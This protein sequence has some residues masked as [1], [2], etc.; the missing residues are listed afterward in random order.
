VPT[1]RVI[2]RSSVL[3]GRQIILRDPVVK[4]G[5]DPK[6]QILFDENADRTVS[7]NHAEV[8][9][10]TI[11]PVLHPAPGKLVFRG[12]HQVTAATPLKSGDIIELAGV[13]GPAVEFIFDPP[14]QPTLA[15]TD[16]DSLA[17]TM[18]DMSVPVLGPPPSAP[19]A[20]IV[21][22]KRAQIQGGT[23]KPGGGA[24]IPRAAVPAG[25]PPGPPEQRGTE[26]LAP[27]DAEA[28][29][30]MDASQAPPS[31]AARSRTLL[32]RAVSIAAVVLVVVAVGAGLWLR[33]QRQERVRLAVQRVEALLAAQAT[34][35]IAPEVSEEDIRLFEEEV[36]ANRHAPAPGPL[37]V[38]HRGKVK[39]THVS[40]EPAE[41]KGESSEETKK[42]SAVRA[43]FADYMRAQI[44]RLS[45]G[46]PKDKS[47][48]AKALVADVKTALAA[49]ETAAKTLSTPPG[50]DVDRL[51]R[52]TIRQL[53][54]C[55]ALAPSEFLSQAKKTIEKMRTD[56]GWRERLTSG[57][58]RAADYRYGPTIT[59]ALADQGLP[60]EL[61]FIPYEMSGFDE[62]RV[63]LPTSG[64][65][66][67]GMW[68]L[69]PGPAEEMGL[70]L[71]KLVSSLDPDSGDDR[72]HYE[73]EV[74]KVAKA[75]R[76]I[77]LQKAAGSTLLF[78]ATYDRGDSVLLLSTKKRAGLA[79]Q[80]SDPANVNFWR[81]YDKGITDDLRH[82]ALEYV[83]IVTM[84]QRP[85]QFG[86]SFA[87]PLEHVALA[88]SE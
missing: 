10:E 72:E 70:K 28:F 38:Q 60:V 76:P 2:Y 48:H 46:G 35:G 23:P 29:A 65:I 12:G 7:R 18:L 81:V 54:E 59:A 83:A 3:N 71:G 55:D 69:L 58:K 5:R 6:C 26:F 68:G 75:F 16:A 27:V 31:V 53:G 86:F 11:G 56:P 74:R 9:W 32:I 57:M 39:E 30:S 79:A 8:V 51:L 67:K 43:A 73:R 25:P 88:E 42:K 61:F 66:P 15:P 45:A 34:A 4:L 44:A 14:A 37:H 40:K 19:A 13:G 78:M 52:K 36:K 50:D 64:G 47:E 33:H 21:T 22:S 20:P 1:L 63:D 24:P 41:P 87:P 82:T 85:D 80:D 17:Q 77:F 62:K 84:A 49:Y